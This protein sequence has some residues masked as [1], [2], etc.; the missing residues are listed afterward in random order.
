MSVSPGP[1]IKARAM[2]LQRP[3]APLVL[4]EV[5][6][7]PPAPHQVLIEI[8]ACG[9]CRTDL[10]LIDGELPQAV[11]P[12]TP[13]H[14]IVGRVIALGGEVANWKVGDR[15][16]VPWLAKSCGECAYCMAGAENL[17]DRPTFTGC[18]VDG[19][20][21]THALADARY[22]LPIPAR[23]TDAEAA[24]LLCAGLIGYR[25]YKACGEA[26]AIGL[27]GFGAAAHLLAQ[28]AL[29]QGREVYAFTRPGDL[30]G[31]KFAREL[32]VAWAGG[33]D[34]P[35]PCRLDAAIIFAPVGALV[36]LALQ[37]LRKGGRVVCAGIHMS[38]IPAFPYELI[39]GERSIHSVANLTRADGLE[40]MR[41]AAEIELRPATQSFDLELANDALGALRAGTVRGAA[42]LIPSR[43]T[44]T[45][46]YECGSCPAG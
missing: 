28:V 37:A 20:Y 2:R 30:A 33:S 44:H 39:W 42:V 41:L 35:P 4:Q 12:A 18:T 1:G 19:G 29:A 16:G 40:F 32:G 5:M 15:L 17:C 7:A 14:E 31:Q 25:A 8:N 38:D 9:V 23:Y 22:C 13:G 27:F 10:H 3:G 36:P 26:K 45:Q 21:A 6:M 46:R 11:Y 43:Q 24:P 34:E